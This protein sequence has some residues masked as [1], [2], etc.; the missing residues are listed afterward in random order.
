MHAQKAQKVQKAQE[1]QKAQ[2]A[3]EAQKS[4]EAPKEQ[5]AQKA[6]THTAFFVLVC[7]YAFLWLINLIMILRV[8][9]FTD[10]T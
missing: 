4:Q 10:K 3:E 5:I 1:V 8:P 7:L 6:Q 9:T 2:Q